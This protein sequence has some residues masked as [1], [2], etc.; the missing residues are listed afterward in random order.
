MLLTDYAHEASA[1]SD[2]GANQVYSERDWNPVGGEGLCAERQGDRYK[3]SKVAIERAAW[4]FMEDSDRGFELVTICPAAIFRPTVRSVGSSGELS[5]SNTHFWN[6]FIGGY[7]VWGSPKKQTVWTYVDVRDCARA[8]FLA[9]D[10]SGVGGRRF[11]V[12]AGRW[13]YGLWTKISRERLPEMEKRVPEDELEVNLGD[14][15]DRGDMYT[16]AYDMDST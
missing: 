3:A 4:K 5:E 2:G 8:Y 11:V 9:L 7:G 6:V 10:A 15:E 1:S 12:S 16:D 14:E 13:N